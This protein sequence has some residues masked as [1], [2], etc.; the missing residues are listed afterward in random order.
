MV[1]MNEK[2]SGCLCY[3]LADSGRTKYAAASTMQ[4]REKMI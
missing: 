3:Y 2:V 4:G 1:K